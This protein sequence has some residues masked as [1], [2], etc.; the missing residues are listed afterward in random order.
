MSCIFLTGFYQYETTLLVSSGLIVFL[1]GIVLA[2]VGLLFVNKEDK[3]YHKA[4]GWLYMSLA[5]VLFVLV[6]T[7]LSVITAAFILN[8]VA[9]YM[10]LR[11]MPAAPENKEVL[12]G[13]LDGYFVLRVLI[14]GMIKA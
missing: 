2:L 5:L 1:V 6:I 7:R 14:P 3:L 13:R 11:G 9:F 8:L 4:A 10:I 12:R